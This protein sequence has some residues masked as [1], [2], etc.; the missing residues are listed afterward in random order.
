MKVSVIC[1]T[2]QRAERHPL[3]Y[4]AFNHQTY[5]DKELLV[6]DDSPEKSPFF[7]NL[8]DDRVTY[9]FLS[10]YYNIGHKRNLL[11]DLAKGE[12]I[13]NF[14]D[15]DFYAPTY[16]QTMV[17]AIQEADFVKLS[18][19]LGWQEVGGRLWEW[20][21]NNTTNN[22]FAVFGNGE[23]KKFENV[24]KE[25]M[26]IP[27]KL[28]K[29]LGCYGF[30]HVFRKSMWEANP[31]ADITFGEDLLFV[32]QAE[33]SEKICKHVTVPSHFILHTL[34]PQSVSNIHPQRYLNTSQAI[35]L[36]GAEVNPW[37]ITFY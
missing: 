31:Y 32:L 12:I 6:I 11:I 16:I 2:Y 15:D 10:S 7:T 36:L 21:A 8:Q 3:L 24:S 30:S 29:N 28:A 27:E 4:T 14:D 9:Q 26:E 1:P 25:D 37:L 35:Q 17:D 5:A 18:K 19:W 22:F 23:V 33:Q 20:D 13:V 34:H